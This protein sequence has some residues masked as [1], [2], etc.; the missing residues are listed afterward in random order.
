MPREVF[1]AIPAWGREYVNL[2][3]R[4]TIPATLA[5]LRAWRSDYAAHFLV[6]TYERDAFEVAL[7]GQHVEYRD[8]QAGPGHDGQWVAFKRAHCEAIA[9]APEGALLALLNSDIVVSI[10]T[11]A[12]VDAALQGEKTVGVSVGI[13]TLIDNGNVPPIGADAET[14][15]RYIWAHRHSIT[16]ECIWGSGRTHHPTIL[17][18]NHAS[19]ADTVVSMHCFHLTPMFIVK[20]RPL[21][22]KGTIDDDLLEAYGEDRIVYFNNREFAVCELSPANKRHPARDP[23]NVAEVVEFGRQRL[24]GSHVRNFRQRFAVL[25]DADSNHQAVDA[26]L[27]GLGPHFP[28]P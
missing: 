12:A 14:L 2:A 11:F 1:I 20:D 28:A 4:Y 27:E 19:L 8:P 3:V 26:I 9:W 23:L 7:R 16:E 24:R 15:S 17:F 25:G 13:R 18:F 5:A 6:H 10:E 21:D 22:F